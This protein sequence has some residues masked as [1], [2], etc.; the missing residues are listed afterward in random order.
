MPILTLDSKQRSE[1]KAT[2][3]A[4][5]PV[6]LIGDAG[7]S[8]TVLKEID[9]NLNAHEL[10]KV[11][12][13]GDDREARIT[14]LN[15]ICDTL[16]CATVGHIGKILIL[17][18]PAPKKEPSTTKPVSKQYVPKKLAASGKTQRSRRRVIRGND[19]IL[20]SRPTA[21]KKSTSKQ[22][23]QRFVERIRNR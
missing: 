18:R 20:P 1:L 14:I 7:L 17:Y 13:A 11:R 6:V 19:D 15:E 22:N 3:H 4:L 10:I 5:K 21:R 8:P 23:A 16:S 2:A 12:V 9:T